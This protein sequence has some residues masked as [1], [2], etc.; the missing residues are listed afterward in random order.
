MIFVEGRESINEMRLRGIE[1][2][3]LGVRDK[4]KKSQNR[5]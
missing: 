4:S 1:I 5:E 2:D 3:R